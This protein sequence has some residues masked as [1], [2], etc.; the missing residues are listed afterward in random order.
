MFK[1]MGEGKAEGK[2]KGRKKTTGEPVNW[3]GSSDVEIYIKPTGLDSAPPTGGRGQDARTEDGGED[4][5]GVEPPV[6]EVVLQVR[7]EH[8]P[9]VKPIGGN[10]GFG[11]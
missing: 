9:P 7:T 11:S 1:N 4:E 5:E 2:L 6:V 10:W 3:R 8:L